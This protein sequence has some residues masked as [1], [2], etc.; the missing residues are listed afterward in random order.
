MI[1]YENLP[2]SSGNIN[3]GV[4]VNTKCQDLLA[5]SGNVDV[6]D[7]VNISEE[8]IVDLFDLFNEPAR[9]SSVSSDNV[10]NLNEKLLN[11]FN[12]SFVDLKNRFRKLAS[13]YSISSVQSKTQVN[14]LEKLII[15]FNVVTTCLA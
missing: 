12:D 11:S 15:A 14:D 6:G 4:D 7:N 3:V 2:A 8:R 5:G 9:V 13:K 1:Y 10:V